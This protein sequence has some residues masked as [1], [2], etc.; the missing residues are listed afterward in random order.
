MLGKVC[1]LILSIGATGCGLLGY[2]QMRLQTLHELANVQKRLVLHDRDLFRLRSEIA[3]RVTPARVAQLAADLG[4][5][6]SIGVND[7]MTEE[8]PELVETG[9]K[10]A[11]KTPKKPA[12]RN[13]AGEDPR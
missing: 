3:E 12:A 13:L 10:P 2:R 5:M 11:R 1:V 6:V 7:K 4:P 8:I 9:T